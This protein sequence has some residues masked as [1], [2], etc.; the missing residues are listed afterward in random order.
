MSHSCRNDTNVMDFDVVGMP[1][2]RRL[3]AVP[4]EDTRVLTNYLPTVRT[5]RALVEARSISNVRL[6]I[7]GS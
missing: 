2:T 4:W 3:T 1:M 6:L 7:S 5:P